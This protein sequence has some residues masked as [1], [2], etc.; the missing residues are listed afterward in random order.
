M[1]SI[2]IP[3]FN[4]DI[5]ELV[6]DLILQSKA[7]H[8]DF[9]ILCYDDGSLPDYKKM[10][11]ILYQQ[12]HVV[13]KELPANIGRSKIRNLLASEAR[14]DYLLFLDCDSKLNRPDF[15]AAYLNFSSPDLVLCGGRDYDKAPPENLAYFLRWYYGI[16][17]ET[18]P[19]A[20]RQEK[21]YKSFMTNNVFIPKALFFTIRFDE[22]VTG[23]GHEDT[24]FGNVLRKKNKTIRH[25]ENP[26]THIGLEPAD[27]FIQ[28]TEE[29]LRNLKTILG[30]DIQL[31]E[32][33]ILNYYEGLKKCKLISP[34]AVFF[35]IF[36]LGVLIGQGHRAGTALFVGELVGVACCRV[37]KARTNQSDIGL[38]DSH[39]FS[40]FIN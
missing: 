39:M 12:E 24:L 10:N 30:Q 17:R 3:V 38:T 25:L 11:A 13:Y 8:I 22:T 20:V 40:S 21:P 7:C 2:L 26:L 19:A 6:S 4:F 5:R 18:I 37:L 14:Y 9:E 28:K 27:T 33:Q 35:L 32:V 15:I 34:A 31:E 29:G 16:K 1:L 23:Y 36:Y